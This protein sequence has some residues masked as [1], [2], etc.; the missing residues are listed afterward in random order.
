MSSTEKRPSKART[1]IHKKLHQEYNTK[2]RS[3]FRKICKVFKID[4]ETDIVI[5][6]KDKEFSDKW[7][8]D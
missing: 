6:E 5:K 7:N 1:A 2:S 3:Y 8:F 4:P